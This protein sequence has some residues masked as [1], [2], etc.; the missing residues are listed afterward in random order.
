MHYGKKVF[1]CLASIISAIMMRNQSPIFSSIA[2]LLGRSGVEFRGILGLLLLLPR[3][4]KAFFLAR[5][6][7]HL[8]LLVRGF[9][10]WFLLWCVGRFGWRGITRYSN[11]IQNQLGGFIGELKSIL[12]WARLCKGYDEIPI[13]DLHRHW[14]RVIGLTEF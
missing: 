8:V 3:T 2:P 10:A 5:D 14:E 4:L 12:L 9:G 6:H 1:I 7:W 11:V 13:R